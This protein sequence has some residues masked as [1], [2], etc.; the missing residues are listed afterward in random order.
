VP[1]SSF[2][3]GFSFFFSFKGAGPFSYGFISPS[4]I[5]VLFSARELSFSNDEAF[6]SSPGTE[7][8]FSFSF[9]RFS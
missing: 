8:G 9:L 3:F 5:V 4:V 1:F 7:P 2:S 6:F